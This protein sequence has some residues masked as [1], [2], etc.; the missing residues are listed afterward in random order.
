MESKGKV[1]PNRNDQN[2]KLENSKT[3]IFYS[4]GGKFYIK[5]DDDDWVEVSALTEIEEKQ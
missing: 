3:L 5:T 4:K 2:K 1:P